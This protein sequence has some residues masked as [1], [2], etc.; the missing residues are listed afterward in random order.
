[1]VII[2]VFSH[3][4]CDSGRTETKPERL[5]TLQAPTLDPEKTACSVSAMLDRAW[6]PPCSSEQL[7]WLSAQEHSLLREGGVI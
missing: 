5:G 4:L 3:L 1:M 7:W 6:P 2:F